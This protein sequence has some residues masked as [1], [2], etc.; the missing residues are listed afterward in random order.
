M[1]GLTRLTLADEFSVQTCLP[2]FSQ[3]FGTDTGTDTHTGTGTGI[4][5]GSA[6]SFTKRHDTE[7]MGEKSHLGCER[8]SPLRN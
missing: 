8:L 6:L 7:E 2:L 3:A 4:G 1:P 5:V